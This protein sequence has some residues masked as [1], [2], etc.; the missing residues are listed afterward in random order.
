[1]HR[2]ARIHQEHH[3]VGLSY[4]IANRIVVHWQTRNNYDSM[5]TQRPDLAATVDHNHALVLGRGQ[6]QPKW[7]VHATRY[8]SPPTTGQVLVRTLRRSTHYPP[9][10]CVHRSQKSGQVLVRTY[11][12]VKHLLPV[13]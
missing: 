11:D 2:K 5:V 13:I 4:R 1:L 6:L 3:R 12:L 9:I 8:T 10:A 7:C